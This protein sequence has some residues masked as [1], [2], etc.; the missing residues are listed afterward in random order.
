MVLAL[1]PAPVTAEEDARWFDTLAVNAGMGIH[2]SS[3]EDHA[4]T[5]ALA[6]LEARREERHSLGVMLFNNSFGQFSQYYF[7]GR[8]WQLPG[9]G[10]AFHVKLTGGIIHGYVGEFKNKVPVN[11]GGWAPAI[12]PAVGWRRDRWGFDAAVLGGA[13][14]MLMLSYEVD[15]H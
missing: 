15:R 10:E 5:P 2:W 14:M 13:G 12:I 4:G 3:S 11:F 6:G 7:Y 8:R 1:L 9:A